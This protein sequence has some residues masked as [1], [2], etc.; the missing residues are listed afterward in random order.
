MAAR[1]RGEDPHVPKWR[2]HS[3]TTEVTAEDL[4]ALPVKETR[5]RYV[6]REVRPKLAARVNIPVYAHVIEG[7]RRGERNPAGPRRVRA[8]VATLDRGVAGGQSDLSTPLRY[9]FFVKR[10]DYTKRD[11]WYHAYLFGP[12]DQKAKRRSAPRERPLAQ[13]VHQRWWPRGARCSDG[14]V[15]LAVPNT[16]RLD[17]VSVN[18]EA[19]PGGA[20]PG[21]NLG[22]T[23]LHESGTGGALPHLRGGLQRPGRPGRGHP[24]RGRAQL[25][26]PGQPRHLQ[27]ERFDP[28]RNFM[29]YLLDTCMNMFS[30]DRCGVWTQ[31]S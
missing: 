13:P 9:R 7:K 31:H 4:E 22:D 27:S 18:V 25:Q 28:V 6:N 11:G 3:D 8:L 15:P 14:P 23:V 21:Y 1:M 19:L 20:A 2:Q 29:D 12:R 30:A 16:P 24:G 10:I 26:V 5:R 17:H